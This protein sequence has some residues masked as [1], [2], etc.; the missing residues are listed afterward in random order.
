M[1]LTGFCTFFHQLGFVRLTCGLEL[2][3]QLLDLVLLH[4]QAGVRQCHL[5]LV[6]LLFYA[7]M[8]LL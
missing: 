2:L 6:L 7:V 5:R 3:L 8:L 4:I 1:L